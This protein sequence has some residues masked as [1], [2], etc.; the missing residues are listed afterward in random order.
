MQS[1]LIN[2]I[3]IAIGEWEKQV[4]CYQLSAG[5]GFLCYIFMYSMANMI[6]KF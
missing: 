1:E 6:L 2:I 5:N 3:S 4:K